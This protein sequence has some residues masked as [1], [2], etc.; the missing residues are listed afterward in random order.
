MTTCTCKRLGRQIGMPTPSSIVEICKSSMMNEIRLGGVM[1]RTAWFKVRG[2]KSMAAL[3]S[4]PPSHKLTGRPR[5][6]TQ[7]QTVRNHSR[8]AQ[9]PHQ[10]IWSQDEKESGRVP[11]HLP[12]YSPQQ[13]SNRG[14]SIVTAVSACPPPRFSGPVRAVMERNR[15]G[16]HRCKPLETR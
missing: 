7:E 4:L 1:V 5:H 3:D 16:G 2:A 12:R 8:L 10:T 6:T 11:T 13:V 14:P 9:S 15:K